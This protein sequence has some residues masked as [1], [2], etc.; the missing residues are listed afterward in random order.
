[1]EGAI[2]LAR[3]PLRDPGTSRAGAHPKKKKSDRK[4]KF[5]NKNRFDKDRKTAARSSGLP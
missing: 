2:T 5:L 4:K 1:M 3:L